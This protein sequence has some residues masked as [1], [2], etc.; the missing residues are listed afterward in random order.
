[1]VRMPPAAALPEQDWKPYAGLDCLTPVPS[2]IVQLRVEPGKRILLGSIRG[3]DRRPDP[4][5][6][7]AAGS[8]RV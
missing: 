8:P 4:H 7:A 6:R 1:M 5:M 3:R 2:R